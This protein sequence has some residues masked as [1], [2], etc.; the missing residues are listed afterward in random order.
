MPMIL[1]LLMKRSVLTMSNAILRSRLAITTNIVIR[2]FN[3]DRIDLRWNE[4]FVQY[5]QWRKNSAKDTSREQNSIGNRPLVAFVYKLTHFIFQFE[6]VNSQSR[7]FGGTEL[8]KRTGRRN[9]KFFSLWQDLF[10]ANEH[11]KKPDVK[12]PETKKKP[13][14]KSSPVVTDSPITF[15]KMPASPY[16]FQR[17]MGFVSPPSQ[18]PLLGDS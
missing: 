14:R 11:V 7:G 9:D 12:K 10:P 17:G 16:T 1:S 6:H 4:S 5:S 2:L 8:R 15:I 18:F 3:N 13:A